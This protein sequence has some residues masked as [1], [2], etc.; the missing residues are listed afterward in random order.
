[1][2]KIFFFCRKCNVDPGMKLG[3]LI[4]EL[5]ISQKKTAPISFLQVFHIPNLRNWSA[6]TRSCKKMVHTN[7]ILI[8]WRQSLCS[9]WWKHALSNPESL[10]NTFFYCLKVQMSAILLCVEYVHVLY[11]FLCLRVCRC[12]MPICTVMQLSWIAPPSWLS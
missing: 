6:S 12:A 2:V 4:N 3:A 11:L 10:F 8:E 7:K 9:L 5:C 1:M